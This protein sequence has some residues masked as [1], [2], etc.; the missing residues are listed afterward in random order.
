MTVRGIVRYARSERRWTPILREASAMGPRS[1]VRKETGMPERGAAG[2]CRLS[3]GCVREEQEGP[4]VRRVFRGNA[5]PIG[6][7]EIFFHTPSVPQ[8]TRPSASTG[9]RRPHTPPRGLSKDKAQ[10]V[11]QP[12]PS[13]PAGRGVEGRR[14]VYAS[15][16]HTRASKFAPQTARQSSTRRGTGLSRYCGGTKT[17]TCHTHSRLPARREHTR[18]SRCRVSSG[19]S[20]RCDAGRHSGARKFAFG[21][22][23]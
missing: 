1:R 23:P 22:S 16:P 21:I 3:V 11:S 15:A 14:P 17:K 8:M 9:K 13:P 6:V 10:T 20:H 4:R 12:D 18:S 2:R 19:R 5:Q 7:S